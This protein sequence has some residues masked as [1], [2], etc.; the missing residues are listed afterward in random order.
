MYYDSLGS[1]ISTLLFLWVVFLIFQRLGYN[2]HPKSNPWKK[3][4]ILTFIQALV[5]TLM[6]PF[7][8]MFMK[9]ILGWE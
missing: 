6:L 4:I 1:I 7:I 2:R 3:D 9:Y 5:V 8:G